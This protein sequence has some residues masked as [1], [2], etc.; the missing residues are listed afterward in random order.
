[1]SK[2]I[3]KYQ[4]EKVC[5]EEVVENIVIKK[6]LAVLFFSSYAVMEF[7]HTSK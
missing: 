1:M 3:F 2:S 6:F 7:N 5:M 4:R